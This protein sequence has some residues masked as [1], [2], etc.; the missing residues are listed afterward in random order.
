M[1]PGVAAATCAGSDRSVTHASAV[2]FGS[3]PGERRSSTTAALSAEPLSTV[4]GSAQF[5]SLP[6]VEGVFHSAAWRG[7]A[8]ARRVRMAA[9]GHAM[10]YETWRSLTD[11]GL[12]DAEGAN[13]PAR[14]HRGTPRSAKS[15][16]SVR[17]PLS[18]TCRAFSPSSGCGIAPRSWSPPTRAGWSKPP[19]STSD[20]KPRC[21]ALPERAKGEGA[22]PDPGAASDEVTRP[23]GAVG[24]PFR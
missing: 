24:G 4:T 17:R 19:N 5:H 14:D 11:Q 8:A 12:S 23:R 20:T 21:R 7:D 15:S 16:S 22:Q 13:A 6:G 2:G 10:S 3:Q 18:R 1:A 9:I